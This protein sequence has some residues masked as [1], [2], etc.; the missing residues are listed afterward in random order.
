VEEERK[1]IKGME[2]KIQIKRKKKR[3]KVRLKERLIERQQRGY[4]C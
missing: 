3:N 4:R 2:R 1:K